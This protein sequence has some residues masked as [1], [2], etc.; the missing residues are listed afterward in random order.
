MAASVLPIVVSH[1]KG[2]A[3]FK[4]SAAIDQLSKTNNICLQFVD[5]DHNIADTYPTNPN[6]SINGITGL[7]SRDGRA[8]I[9]M[10]H[11]EGV[12]RSAQLSWCPKEWLQA[13]DSP[14]MRIF[15][16]VQAEL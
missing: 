6:G 15:Y 3:V 14:W 2:K 8:T 4:N 11:P 1:G 5:K 10:P 13:D 12:F 16:I 7:C 9:M